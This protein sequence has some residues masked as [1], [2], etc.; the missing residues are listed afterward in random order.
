MAADVKTLADAI[1]T[2]INTAAIF[3]ATAAFTYDPA[4]DL[5]DLSTERIDV[6][7]DVGRTKQRANRTQVRVTQP[8]GVTIR[9]RFTGSDLSGEGI[10]ATALDAYA[11]KCDDLENLLWRGFVSAL[12]AWVDSVEVREI[13][14]PEDLRENCMFRH[15]V[16]F[17]CSWHINK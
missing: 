1:A 3:T 6:W 12:N 10:A 17:T 9:K 4:A 13:Y 5:D 11:S 14:S 2:A 7:E 8:I 16:I 15:T